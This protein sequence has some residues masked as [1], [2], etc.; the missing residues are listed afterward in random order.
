V[1]NPAG[2][3]T[4]T[5]LY[6]GNSVKTTDQAGK[7][8][9]HTSNVFGN[10]I[11]VNEPN[12]AGGADYVTTYT[13]N[14]HGQLTGVS[15]P[16]P[17]GTQTRTFTY[18][19]A[20]GRL[21]SAQNP[22]N[23]TVSYTYN[24]DGTVATRNHEGV[25]TA[26]T[27]DSLK[28]LTKTRYQNDPNTDIDYSYDSNPFGASV[29]VA[30]RLAAVRWGQQ[31]GGP[32]R[33]TRTY[34]YTAAGQVSKAKME[35][36]R[37]VQ[38]GN[39]ATAYLE[40]NYTYDNEGK[41]AS[42]RDP[43]CWPTSYCGSTGGTLT[44]AYDAMGRPE[45]LTDDQATPIDWVKD[46]LY[47]AAGQMAEWNLFDYWDLLGG[48]AVHRKTWYT[49]NANL[50]LKEIWREGFPSA[51]HTYTHSPTQNNGRVTAANGVS[52]TYDSLNRLSTAV[53][54]S[55]WGLSFTYDGFGNRTAQTVTVGSGP[56]SS[57]S[58]NAANN[59]VTSWNYDARGNVTWGPPAGG[60]AP[61]YTYDYENRLVSVNFA[62]PESYAYG[63]DNRRVWK[64]QPDGS[65]YMYWYD[66]AGKQVGTYEV[67]VGQSSVTLNRVAGRMYF[68]GRLFTG[69]GTPEDRLGS[70]GTYYP[71]GEDM[72]SGPNNNLKFATYY[73]DETT[74]FDYA[75]NRY[76]LSGAGRFLT[77]DP[78]L[79]SGGAA[80]PGS[81]NR[82]AYVEGD[83]VNYGDPPG[84]F[85]CIVGGGTVCW[86]I[87]A[88]GTSGQP[89]GSQHAGYPNGGLGTA[90][91][92]EVVYSNPGEN[93]P[94]PGGDPTCP[95]V[96]NAPPGASVDAN[97]ALA[98]SR[99]KEILSA[100]SAEASHGGLHVATWFYLQVRNDGPW[101]Y[102]Q[103]DKASRPPNTPS[104]FEDFG[105]FNFGAT[106]K[107][108][109][110][111]DEVTL[112]MAGWA[113][114][115]ARSTVPRQLALLVE[116]IRIFTGT[117]T[118]PLPYGDTAEDQAA[119]QRGIEYFNLKKVG[120]I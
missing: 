109:G 120:C 56:S 90:D 100:A 44:Y 71:Y 13:Y 51:T 114:Q 92:F 26:Y 97:I 98:E 16:R 30:G 66:L 96:P 80:E 65:E 70:Y 22:E 4:T 82:Y 18:D 10:L 21:A 74:G 27:Y 91:L 12:P 41:M 19:L 83:P 42:F 9:R 55:T 48:Y 15:M 23:G 17:T 64:K 119:I 7:W 87:D 35:V 106:A 24:A 105:N 36:Y 107:A 61:S 86:S 54:G 94:G 6:E 14:I 118:A 99:A 117:A 29:N 112:R 72:F 58:V 52:Y 40:S 85:R 28:R 62:T 31:A 38:I 111:S 79:A 5:I 1:T 77:A 81:W 43:V 116:L 115:M 46:V 102:K 69:G 47:G 33:L 50:Q 37:Q 32:G 57:L 78:Y 39:P 113:H 25:L 84:L 34:E 108:V 11:Q 53:S 104:A 101:D 67:I 93:D 63:P 89:P 8:K 20:T 3:G 110:F 59:R 76:Y 95:P 73:R 60:Y 2:D 45:R 68:A 88:T 49:Y 75:V 103:I